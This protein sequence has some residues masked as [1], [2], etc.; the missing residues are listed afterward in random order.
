MK[1]DTGLPFR[2][3]FPDTEH[4]AV[5]SFLR[6]LSAS[7]CSPATLR[8]YAYDLLRWFRFLHGRFVAWE[9]AERLDVRALVEHMRASPTANALRRGPE[10]AAATNAVT[11]KPGAGTTFSAN[12]INHQLTV[13]SSFYDFAL[14]MNLGRTN[15]R[16]QARQA[17]DAG[18]PGPQNQEWEFRALQRLGWD[19]AFAW[20]ESNNGRYGKS[21][22][23][24]K[25]CQRATHDILHWLM[26]F[27]AIRGM[28]GGLPPGWMRH[29]RPVLPNSAGVWPCP[30]STSAWG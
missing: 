22:Q 18:T 4:Q 2:L 7:D 20:V 14:E 10:N 15:H 8:S 17:F 19:E 5:S 30:H 21:K 12:S 29:Q 25:A 26:N 27:L 28:N 9:R 24:R 6:D 11:R 23:Y 13:L 3:L 1:S 16:I